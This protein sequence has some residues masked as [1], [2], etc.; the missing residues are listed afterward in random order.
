MINQLWD[1]TDPYRSIYFAHGENRELV[2]REHREIVEAAR[3][4][5]KAKVVRLLATHRKNAIKGLRR[6]LV[7][8]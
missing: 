2:N 7:Q 5:D 6:V 3:T 1:T 8:D 4:R